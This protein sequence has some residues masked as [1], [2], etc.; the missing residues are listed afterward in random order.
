[1]SRII[2]T[3]LLLLT[4]GLPSG[5]RNQSRFRSLT[6]QVSYLTAGLTLILL[7]SIFALVRVEL[8]A[9]RLLFKPYNIWLI[10]K[11][12]H[13]LSALVKII[14]DD[15]ITTPLGADK[16]YT[17]VPYFMCYTLGLIVLVIYD[18]LT[19]KPQR[20]ESPQ[21]IT[22]DLN[23]M[24][25]NL[26]PTCD[27]TVYHG[28][29]VEE[30]SLLAGQRVWEEQQGSRHEGRLRAASNGPTG[31]RES[32]KAA[33]PRIHA[34]LTVIG[35][36]TSIYDATDL[37]LF[38]VYH[39][40]SKL[41][42]LLVHRRDGFPSIIRCL[43]SPDQTYEIINEPQDLEIV[44]I[45]QPIDNLSESEEHAMT[46]HQNTSIQMNVMGTQ[47]DLISV[48]STVPDMLVTTV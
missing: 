32:L 37:S 9:R 4:D 23:D 41:F 42:S 19:S 1:M 38:V 16:F 22:F 3:D 10:I 29:S 31:F 13:S 28:S 44:T 11:I 36:L 47:T 2:L 30:G 40:F 18:A 35:S 26:I 39:S 15:G 24:V 7:R 34:A 6:H 43:T 21:S 48:T 14:S 17:L 45:T 25:W 5:P 27:V 12:Y 33:G 8:F 46:P 20:R